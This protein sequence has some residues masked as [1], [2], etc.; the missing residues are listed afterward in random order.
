MKKKVENWSGEE[1]IYRIKRYQK[2]IPFLQEQATF[3]E[4]ILKEMQEGVMKIIGNN[5]HLRWKVLTF[6]ETGELPHFLDKLKMD[7]N[8]SPQHL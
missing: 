4:E 8:H 3:N 2:V 6:F 7:N 1:L 5:F